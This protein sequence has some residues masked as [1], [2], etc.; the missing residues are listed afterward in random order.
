MTLLSITED[1]REKVGLHLSGVQ[2]SLGRDFP[3]G[4]LERAALRPHSPVL[5]YLFH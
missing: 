5:F 1:L 3:E 4:I 2:K